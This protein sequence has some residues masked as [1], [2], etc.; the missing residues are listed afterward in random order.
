MGPA[1]IDPMAGQLQVQFGSHITN[2]GFV[3]A[4][5]M[6][7]IFVSIAK[8]PHKPPNLPTVSEYYLVGFEFVKWFCLVALVRTPSEIVSAS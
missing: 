1:A 8:H 7:A 2:K 4:G 6:H 5:R 3:A